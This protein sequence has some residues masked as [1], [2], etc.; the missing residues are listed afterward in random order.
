M[1]KAWYA[2]YASNLSQRRFG[3]YLHG[4]TLPETGRYHPGARDPSPPEKNVPLWLPGTVYFATRNTTWGS[5]G[6]AL[7]DPD[8]PG[9]AAAHGYLVTT[10]QF[11]D[12]VAQ[13]MQ[14]PPGAFADAAIPVMAGQRVV[15]G[16]G[17]YETLV[18]TQ[19]LDGYPVVTMAA[20]WSLGD[21]P[22]VPLAG[23]YR[24]M[25]IAGLMETFGWWPEQAQRY[26]SGLPG[27]NIEREEP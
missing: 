7:Y 17:H 25:I 10:G 13:E 3:F 24:A 4:G 8:A 23:G 5:T 20:P 19:E 22:L 6:R 18:C 2:S 21:V 12:V 9:K 26:L 27:G 15:L 11:L 16:G 14:L 1:D